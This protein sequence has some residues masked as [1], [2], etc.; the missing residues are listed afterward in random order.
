MKTLKDWSSIAE[1]VASIAV[2]VSVFF[3]VVELRSNTNAIQAQ[4]YQDLT[5]QLNAWRVRT[6]EYPDLR[7][8]DFRN[9]DLGEKRR[10]RQHRLML[11]AI[12]ESAY[13]AQMRG[14]LGAEEWLRFETAVCRGYAVDS[15]IWNWSEPEWTPTS[16]DELLTPSF[17]G[18]VEGSCTED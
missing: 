6:F 12:Y 2:V 1:I 14:I 16:M 13:F 4:T 8:L 9:A 15:F 10:W 5:T 3:I 11:W 18:Y 17:V 7:G